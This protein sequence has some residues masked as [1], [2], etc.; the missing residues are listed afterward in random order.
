MADSGLHGME[1]TDALREASGVI[2]DVR[3]DFKRIADEGRPRVL[4]GDARKEFFKGMTADEF[5][6]LHAAA[7]ELGPKGLNAL[8]RLLVESKQL[9]GD[10]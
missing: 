5:E 3:E 6:T 1:V 2:G 10:E 8:E 4:Q 9:M 7:F